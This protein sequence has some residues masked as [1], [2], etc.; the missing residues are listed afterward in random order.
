MPGKALSDQPL[1][2]TAGRDL[3]LAFQLVDEKQA[4]VDWPPGELFLEVGANSW[5]FSINGSVAGLRVE[6][7]DVDG[8][9][10]RARWQ[11]W[12]LPDG[13]SAGGQPIALGYVRRQ[14]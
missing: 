14:R 6:S 13:E 1:F 12:F 4:P 9:A 5:P 11:L 10:P 2:V 3:E 7:E 8:F